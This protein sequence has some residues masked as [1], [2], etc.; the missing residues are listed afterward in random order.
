MNLHKTAAV[1]WLTITVAAFIIAIGLCVYS[2]AADQ[3]LAAVTSMMVAGYGLLML[4]F[5]GMFAA[6]VSRAK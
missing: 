6:T 2:V 5:G 3:P 1:V 4:A